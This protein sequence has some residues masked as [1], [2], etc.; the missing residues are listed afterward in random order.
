MLGFNCLLYTNMALEEEFLVPTTLLAFTLP[1]RC[2][3]HL[4]YLLFVYIS[5]AKVNR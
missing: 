5:P 2:K 1:V 3:M 4:F